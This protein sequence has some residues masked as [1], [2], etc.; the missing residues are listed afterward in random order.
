MICEGSTKQKKRTSLLLI[1]FLFLTTYLS[2][3]TFKKVNIQNISVFGSELFSNEDIVANSSLNFPTPLILVK[4]TYIEKE[5]KKNLSLEN[6][7]VFRQVFPFR[8]KILI[9]TRMPVARGE[10]I[11]RGQKVTGFVDKN[12]FFINDKYSDKGVLK[13]LSSRVFGWKED[14]RGT[15]SKILNFQENNDIEFVKISFSSNGFLTLEE[16]NL[17]TILLGFNP[18]LIETQLQMINNF[19]NQLKDQKILEKIDNI[20]LTDPNNPKIKVFKP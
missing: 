3:K 8:L 12:G 19:K 14:F 2:S 10:K 15:L 6:V 7:G 9:K 5:L 13:N 1:I 11:I 16:K 17:K 20:D 4:T 18:K